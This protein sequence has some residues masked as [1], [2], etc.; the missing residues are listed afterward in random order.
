MLNKQFDE[1]GGIVLFWFLFVLLIVAVISRLLEQEYY[2][3]SGNWYP[4]KQ[5]IPKL[6]KISFDAFFRSQLFKKGFSEFSEYNENPENKGV[7]VFYLKERRKLLCVA[8][9]DSKILS[10]RNYFTF[11]KRITE[12]LQE[13]NIASKSMLF[14]SGT[15]FPVIY[16]EK[17]DKKT[18]EILKDNAFEYSGFYVFPCVASL[19]E[20]TMYVVRTVI[21]YSYKTGTT[22][23]NNKKAP[24]IIYSILNDEDNVK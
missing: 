11:V 13:Y 12:E 16:C 6:G 19:D 17:K 21:S 4:S 18:K 15:F 5:K 20:R 3:D 9:I 23:H 2:N 22:K 24:S 10:K 8:V 1:S 14:M 7:Q